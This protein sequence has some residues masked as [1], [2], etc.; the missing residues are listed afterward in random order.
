MADLLNV[1][2][3]TQ[4]KI[5]KLSI[6]SKI[7]VFDIS[8]L[9]DELNIFDTI[10]FPCM[11][12]NIV[13]RDAIG[14]TKKLYFDGSEFLEL[15]IGKGDEDGNTKIKKTFRIYKQAERKNI[16]QTSEMYVLHF[17]SEELI[18]SLSSAKIR[19]GYKGNYH[20]AVIDIISTNLKAGNKI[21]YIE[22]TEGIHSFVVP[23]LS[24]NPSLG[25]IFDAL[26][27]IASRSV[28]LENIPNYF[29]FENRSGFNFISLGTLLT[30]KELFTINFKPKNLSTDVSEEFLGARDVRVVSQYNLAESIMDGV[31]AGTLIEYDPMTQYYNEKKFNY[32]NMFIGKKHANLFPNITSLKNRDGTD[33]SQMFDARRVAF[34]SP[35]AR[36]SPGPQNSYIKEYDRETSNLIDDTNRYK[37]Q[38][39]PIVT[40]LMQKRLE[41]TL[42]G[43]FTLS[44]GYTLFLNMPTRSV[45][46]DFGYDNTLYGKYLITAAR[47]IIR[48]DRHETIVELATD[49]TNNEFINSD[50][51]ALQQAGIA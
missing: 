31:Y 9:F 46:D 32:T 21:G 22:K 37:F 10:F 19:K 49:T 45:A 38:R 40:N 3:T 18:Y 34:V 51:A 2:Q 14:L 30:Q 1:G 7:G 4:F 13:I 47:H 25:G 17:V 44:A 5:K 35:A 16:N 6:I 50:T 28:G 48:Y 27:W 12:G 20:D 43:N 39:K 33:L 15:E 24:P 29:F 41:L 36:Q 11:S 42:P 23:N 26:E 8:T